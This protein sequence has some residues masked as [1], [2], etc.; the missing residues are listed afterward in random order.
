MLDCPIMGRVFD[1]I[2]QPIGFA[3]E[4]LGGSVPAIRDWDA[5]LGS[6]NP[7]RCRHTKHSLRLQTQS[8]VP[9][10]NPSDCQ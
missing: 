8:P 10:R 4:R 3:D 9:Y 1:E 7:V 6:N 2:A 5:R